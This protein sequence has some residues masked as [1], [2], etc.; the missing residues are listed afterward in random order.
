[1]DSV[2]V[3]FEAYKNWEDFK[4]KKISCLIATLWTGTHQVPLSMGFSRQEYCCQWVA[5][6]CS[7]DFIGSS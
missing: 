2:I 1:M 6:S 7:T 3:R 4:K 5:S